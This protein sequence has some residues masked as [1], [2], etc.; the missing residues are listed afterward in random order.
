M[1]DTPVD[2]DPFRSGEI[3]RTVP[4]TEPQREILASALLSDAANIAFNEGVSLRFPY[5]VDPGEL[6]RALTTIAQRHES[7]RTT[8]TR[9]GDELCVAT[10]SDFA[11]VVDD[12]SH[13]AETDAAAAIADVWHTLAATPMDL[14]DGPLFQATL[15]VLPDNQAEL[16]LMAHHVICDGWSFYIILDE[17]VDLL[18]G[19]APTTLPVSFADFAERQH[20]EQLSNR[21]IDYWLSQYADSVP[22]L[23]LPTDRPRPAERSFS[24]RRLDYTIDATATARIKTLAGACQASLVQTVFAGVTAL[25]YRLGASDDFAVGLPVAR[26]ASEGLAALLGHAVQLLP[27]R[28]SAAPDQTFR[29]LVAT[30][31]SRILDAQEH[32]NFTFGSLVRDLGYS[33][34]PARVPI[35]PVIFNID[36]PFGELN[37]GE[38]ALTAQ[39]VPRLGENFELFLNVMPS[40]AG[41]RIETTYNTDLF[42][43]STITDWLDALAMILDAAHAT[44]DVA[45]SGLWRAGASRAGALEG[46]T[47]TPFHN[48]W[49]DGFS[50]HVDIDPQR[51]VAGD[52]AEQ[53]SRAEM[54]QRA[55]TL[56]MALIARGVAPGDV[57]AHYLTRGV[58]LPATILGIQLAGATALPLDPDFPV[59]RLAYMLGDSRAGVVVHDRP[60]PSALSV[61]VTALE[62]NQTLSQ[63]VSATLPTLTSDMPAYLIYTSGSTGQPKGVQVSHGALQNFLNAM[64]TSPGFAEPDRL[65]AVTT[66]SFDISLLECLLPMYSGGYV[67]VATRD[68]ASDSRRLQQLIERTDITVMQATPATW[69]LLLAGRWPGRPKLKALC[70]GETLPA[71]LA[72][73][74]LPL[75]GELWNMYGP[76]E[77]TIWSSCK[78]IEPGFESITIGSPIA[79]TRFVI[80]DEDGHAL[81]ASVPGE[82]CIGGAGLADGYRGRPELNNTRFVRRPPYGRLYRTGDQA[83]RLASGDV[84]MLGRLDDQVKVRGF[85]IE[86]GDIE[87][88]LRAFEG[89]RSAAAYV[90]SLS[91]HDQRI[92]ACC[93]LEQGA[94]L[95]GNQ[96]R[97]FL[98]ERLPDYMI[99]QHFLPIAEI[100]LSPSGKVNRR[101]LPRPVAVSSKIGTSTP[102]ANAAEK[103]I[104]DI[105]TTLI[106]PER[107]VGRESRFFEIGGHSLLGLEAIFRIEQ[108]LSVRLHP[109]ILFIEDLAGVAATCTDASASDAGQRPLRLPAEAPRALSFGQL[110][111]AQQ[112]SEQP[113]TTVYNLPACFR[114]TGQLDAARLEAS[115]GAVFERHDALL[116]GLSCDSSAEPVRADSARRPTLARVENFAGTEAAAAAYVAK[117]ADQVIDLEIDPLARMV[118]LSAP[119]QIHYLGF[120]PHQFA[121][122][123][124]SFDVFLKDLEAAYQRGGTLPPSP[125]SALPYAD[126][127]TWQRQ[128]TMAA[129]T[130][131]YWV[132]RS[133]E[134]GELPDWSA[135]ERGEGVA[136]AGFTLPLDIVEKMEAR[137]ANASRKLADVALAIFVRLLGTSAGTET[138]TLDLATSGRY[139][140]E[141]FS[142]IGLFYQDLPLALPVGESFEDSLAGSAEAIK[143]L[144]LHQN[145]ARLQIESHCGALI[146]PRVA[147]SFQQASERPT[148]FGDLAF[149][150][151]DVPRVAL[152]RDMDYWMRRTPEGVVAQVDFR[153]DRVPAPAVQAL[154]GEM[155]AALRAYV[156]GDTS[157]VTSPVP[158]LFVAAPGKPKG[159]LSRLF[160]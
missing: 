22:E 19:R 77:T 115:L 55:R 135:V 150:Q 126:F 37:V 87:A 159:L 155:V 113:G 136:A 51:P 5:A 57:V 7:L 42:N 65:L 54:M 157:V 68:V 30:A 72:R 84:Q 102:P 125:R 103:A 78:R 96:I 120:V 25:L 73:R 99:P 13:L 62:L 127:A 1:T 114:F 63:R 9:T 74:L 116:T 33:G 89:V 121:F 24:A 138:V 82:L 60:V 20:A 142:V 4:S 41:L 111:I 8:F 145:A 149:D 144:A 106:K 85:R 124:W 92:V 95:P 59:A 75:V 90:W 160:S 148:R 58:N 31:K 151:I 112:I 97:K 91:E 61:S 21:D 81:P 80:V 50:R 107:P 69:R 28:M 101:A 154:V 64:A 36:Q 88:A 26:Q 11:L 100:P 79:N 133:G 14:F 10:D 110:A 66:A 45:L 44:P 137:A 94:S 27:V 130:A 34:D 152:M 104:A 53:L 83:R 2:Y 56:A 109:R 117:M 122:D 15:I 132:A 3:A 46:P 98:R 128:Q 105:W 131:A 47:V 119:S 52:E 39:S 43:A 67:H 93:V 123:G 139:L 156:R 71:D 48:A 38:H 17:L 12:R 129:D 143:E 118:L 147:F 23:D 40:D 29:E 32:A 6:E 18:C 49:I 108:R 153:A 76:T 70:G 86:L 158:D 16:V 134:H 141:L 140:P 35:V 146:V